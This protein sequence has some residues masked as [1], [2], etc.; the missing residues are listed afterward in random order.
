V[1]KL[2]VVKSGGVRYGKVWQGYKQL[3]FR[4]EVACDG[5]RFGGVW[6]GWVW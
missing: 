2:G 6:S 1:V 4:I 3:N 5:V